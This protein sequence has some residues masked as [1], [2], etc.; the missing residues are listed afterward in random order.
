MTRTKKYIRTQYGLFDYQTTARMFTACLRQTATASEVAAVREVL[1]VVFGE[2]DSRPPVA[3]A[4]EL[5][6]EIVIEEWSE[7]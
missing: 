7:D 6:P 2:T 4:E 3:L 1:R 5:E